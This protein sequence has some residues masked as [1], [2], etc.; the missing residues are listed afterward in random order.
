VSTDKFSAYENLV[1]ILECGEIWGTKRF[2]KG[3]SKA[4]C[5]MDVPF[6]A[7]K[8][9]LDKENSDAEAPRYEPYGIVVSKKYAYRN[10]CRP[11]LYLSSDEMS[12]L[13][14]PANE[15]WRIVRFEVTK[16]RMISWIHERE[17]RCKGAFTL[18]KKL[19][20]VLVR[21]PKEAAALAKKT[22]SVRNFKALPMSII[23]IEVMCQGLPYLTEK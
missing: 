9:I 12:Q 8:F 17:W 21:T 7:L 4:S 11:V 19:F 14:I 18:P 22:I 1:S 15:Q 10:G 16:T 20:A 2:I 6:S 23:P 5:F 13:A 3:P